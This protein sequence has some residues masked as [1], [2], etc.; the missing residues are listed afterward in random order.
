M[1]MHRSGTHLHSQLFVADTSLRKML[2]CLVLQ[3]ACQCCTHLY[4]AAGHRNCRW[5]N[6]MDMIWE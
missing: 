4:Q 2:L 5:H 6:T 1:L 3:A